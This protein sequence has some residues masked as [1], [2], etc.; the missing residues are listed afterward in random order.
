MRG[1]I[2]D[3]NSQTLHEFVEEISSN[4][5]LIKHNDQRHRPKMLQVHERHRQFHMHAS[6]ILQVGEIY[7]NPVFLLLSRPVKLKQNMIR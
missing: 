3:H 6:V 1:F 4:S 5:S 2:R 7:L